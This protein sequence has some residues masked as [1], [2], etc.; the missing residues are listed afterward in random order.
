[1]EQETK[2]LMVKVREEFLPSFL[3]ITSHAIQDNMLLWYSEWVKKVLFVMDVNFISLNFYYYNNN[4]Q[5]G[6][7][8]QMQK[9]VKSKSSRLR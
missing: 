1:M 8:I 7:K 5:A 9:A 6:N 3:Y 4:K 2:R